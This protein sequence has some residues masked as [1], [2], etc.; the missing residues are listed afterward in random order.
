M[1]FYIP[2]PNSTSFIER[3][4]LRNYLDAQ[5][6]DYVLVKRLENKFFGQKSKI[7]KQ[8]Y[9]NREK[10]MKTDKINK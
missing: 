7:W 2:L 4:L 10:C 3:S 5:K 6:I 8:I 9:Q 1:E